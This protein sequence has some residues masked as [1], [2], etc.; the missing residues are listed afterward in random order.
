[1][2]RV[3]VAL[4]S[5]LAAA[6]VAIGHE[7]PC[8]ED[9]VPLF[10]RRPS[11]ESHRDLLRAAASSGARELRL[12]IRRDFSSFD[13]EVRNASRVDGEALQRIVDAARGLFSGGAAV[14]GGHVPHWSFDFVVRLRDRDYSVEAEWLRGGPCGPKP[15]DLTQIEAL[16]YVDMEV[17]LPLSARALALGQGELPP[18]LLV[19]V[20]DAWGGEPHKRVRGDLPTPHVFAVDRRR[21]RDRH[22]SYLDLAE[23][24]VAERARERWL[25]YGCCP[26]LFV[27]LQWNVS[28]PNGLAVDEAPGDRPDSLA[29]SVPPPEM[30]GGYTVRVLVADSVN[31]AY[32]GHSLMNHPP[33][34]WTGQAFEKQAPFSYGWLL[35]QA[36]AEARDDS[37][38]WSADFIRY[39]NTFPHHLDIEM[40]SAVSAGAT[41]DR[42]RLVV[43]AGVFP[44]SFSSPLLSED[45]EIEFRPRDLPLIV[46]PFPPVVRS[47]VVDHGFLVVHL[48]KAAPMER[49]TQVFQV[50]GGDL[51]WLAETEIEDLGS[52]V[53]Y[54]SAVQLQP[55]LHTLTVGSGPLDFAGNAAA[56]RLHVEFESKP[57]VV[58]LV[59]KDDETGTGTRVVEEA[60][61]S[62][63]PD[64]RPAR[65]HELT[66][67]TAIDEH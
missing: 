54:H 47:V 23:A 63:E 12:T 44:N 65:C 8:S 42:F 15:G 50:D 32:V 55:G 61:W 58:Y 48:S 57:W 25:E 17:A 37:E 7:Q 41:D 59:C 67:K 19:R 46:D 31:W 22:L 16:P 9:D 20:V 40:A 29:R 34:L 14:L 6:G 3:L 18:T 11:L 62:A 1:M 64:P 38:L 26:G 39:L 43:P 52:G 28:E 45:L 4:G 13:I 10:Y 51:E 36:V 27:L 49:F 24:F 56:S 35:A 53:R 33:S 5:L 21:L 66:E 60:Q 2:I 30:P